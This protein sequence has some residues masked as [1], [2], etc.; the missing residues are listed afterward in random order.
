MPACSD[1]AG[2]PSGPVASSV[3]LASPG[4]GGLPRALY[5]HIPFCVRRCRYCDFYSNAVS[6]ADPLVGEYAEAL[7]ALVTRLGSAGC[8]DELATAYVGGGTP[9]MAGEALTTL[10]SS[11]STATVGRLAEFSSE[12]NPESLTSELASRLAEAGLTRVSLGV[13]SFRDEELERL[14][15]SHDSRRAA[16]A[17]R[18]VVDAGLDLSVDLM[19]GIPLQTAESWRRSLEAALACGAGHVSCYPLTVEEGTEMARRV[20]AGLEQAPDEDF[21]AELMVEAERVLGARG[22]VRYEVASYALPGRRCA[23]NVAYW[24]GAPYLGLGP[25]ASGMLE[26]E[27]LRLLDGVALFVDSDDDGPSSAEAMTPAEVLLR[28]PDAWRF[29]FRMLGDARGFVRAMRLGEPVACEVECL[30]RREAAAEDLMLGMRMSDGL[31]ADVLERAVASGVPAADLDR[32]LA[33]LVAEGLVRRLEN[34]SFV[35]TERGWLLGNRVY[36][37]LWDLA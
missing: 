28:H 9:T 12:A 36:G 15:R 31:G 7:A 2:T 22:L 8:L 3:P 37:A 30:T 17:A 21:Q 25:G 13:Q 32:T 16:E 29:R 4:H 10:V 19:C 18:A 33:S 23:H 11:V 5:L 6:H 1:H 35:P 24:T 34:G 20:D 26:G 27:A 14:G